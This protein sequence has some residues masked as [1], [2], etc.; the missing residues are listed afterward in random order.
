MFRLNGRSLAQSEAVAIAESFA[1]GL[2]KTNVCGFCDL[3]VDFI[4]D[5]FREITV[6]AAAETE[7]LLEGSAS[8]GSEVEM[9]AALVSEDIVSA[10]ATAYAQVCTL[11][12]I[13]TMH[14]EKPCETYTLGHVVDC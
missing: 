5:S 6:T 3:A 1:D 14:C 10:S 12:Y 11:I 9:F 2:V 8:D 7:L 13:H 4:A